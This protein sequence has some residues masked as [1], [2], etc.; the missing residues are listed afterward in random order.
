MLAFFLHD[1]RFDKL[2]V[3]NALSTH[4]VALMAFFSAVYLTY[5]TFDAA[6]AYVCISFITSISVSNFFVMS[7]GK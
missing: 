6:I 4:T 3:V 5:D 2:L 1:T 7:K